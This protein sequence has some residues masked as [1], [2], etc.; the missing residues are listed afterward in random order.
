M[1]RPRPPLPTQ[2]HP[3]RGCRDAPTPAT[4]PPACTRADDRDTSPGESVWRSAAP[5][6]GHARPPPHTAVTDP[7][8]R[9]FL[10][11]SRTDQSGRTPPAR[12]SA[13][14]PTTPAAAATSHKSPDSPARTRPGQ[15]RPFVGKPPHRKPP[16]QPPQQMLAHLLPGPPPPPRSGPIQ[17]RPIKKPPV[18]KL[19]KNHRMIQEVNL[20]G[21]FYFSD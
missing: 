15:R 10:Q 1:L 20:L 7:H 2:H 4:P 13:T 19:C 8:T 17:T 3:F 9:Q 14:A 5:V 12:P 18:T 21:K 6:S 16:G 11:A